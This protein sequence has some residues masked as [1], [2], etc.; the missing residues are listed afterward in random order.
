M[1]PYDSLTANSTTAEIA[2]AYREFTGSSGGNTTANQDAAR[3]FLA[4]R[5]IADLE[6]E[7]AYNLFE[8]ENFKAET[9][10]QLKAD[11]EA[12][13]KSRAEIEAMTLQ[14]Q[15]MIRQQTADYEAAQDRIRAESDAQAQAVALEQAMLQKQLA[16]I[17][18]QQAAEAAKAK[19]NMESM[20]RTSAEKQAAFKKA[21]RSAGA[22]PLLGAATPDSMGQGGQ[23]LGS[24]S[25]LSGQS[26]SLGAQQT[27]GVG[28]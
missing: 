8:L 7:K 2:A 15:E 5:G 14:E 19:A 22:R 10:A 11:E 9:D 6:I 25:S 1:A 12:F 13:A 4:S 28:A 18:G 16:D 26:G 23:S 20:Q 21:G 27:L 3:T 17:Q 24:N